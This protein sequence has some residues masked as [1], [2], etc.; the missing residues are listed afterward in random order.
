MLI[1]TTVFLT[2]TALL[3]VLA[4]IFRMR[5]EKSLL[6]NL[7]HFFSK[8]ASNNI[9]DVSLSQELEYESVTNFAFRLPSSNWLYVSLSNNGRNRKLHFG[10]SSVNPAQTS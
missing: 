6:K 5:F 10:T 1:R 7:R 4:D 2:A 3:L 9:R 8:P